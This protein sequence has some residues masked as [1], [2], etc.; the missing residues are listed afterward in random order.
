MDFLNNLTGNN[1]AA[2]Q[3]TPAQQAVSPEQ[4]TGQGSGVLGSVRHVSKLLQLA[5]DRVYS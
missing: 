4:H 5:S 1:N 2:A 3:P